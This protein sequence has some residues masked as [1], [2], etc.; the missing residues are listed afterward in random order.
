MCVRGRYPQEPFSQMSART[1]VGE[2]MFSGAAPK[3]GV[4]MAR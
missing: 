2:S 1:D 4:C 3:S